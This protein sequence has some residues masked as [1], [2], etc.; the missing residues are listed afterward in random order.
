MIE[1][2]EENRLIKIEKWPI[3][4]Q[5]PFQSPFN[6]TPEPVEDQSPFN[7]T[8]EPVEGQ[9]PFQSLSI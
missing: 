1:S 6:L 8:P 7:L 2:I 4:H 3:S 5:S 9:F